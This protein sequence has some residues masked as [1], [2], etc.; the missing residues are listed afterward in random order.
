VSEG[1]EKVRNIYEYIIDDCEN[2]VSIQDYSLIEFI[3]KTYDDVKN[4]ILEDADF[5]YEKAATKLMNVSSD[6]LERFIKDTIYANLYC[7]LELMLQHLD[8]ENHYLK[9]KY[10][11]GGTGLDSKESDRFRKRVLQERLKTYDVIADISKRS[12]DYFG[13]REDK[14]VY[15]IPITMQIYKD[16]FFLKRKDENTEGFS[17]HYKNLAKVLLCDTEAENKDST[18]KQAR[19]IMKNGSLWKLEGKHVDLIIE[20]FE[21]VCLKAGDDF[22]FSEQMLV[23]KMFGLLTLSQICAKKT[24]FSEECISKIIDT[25][26]PIHR[27]GYC[28]LHISIINNLQEGNS[29]E[30]G[31]VI[32]EYIYQICQYVLIKTLSGIFNYFEGIGNDSRI[33]L[34]NKYL[35]DCKEKCQCFRLKEENLVKRTIDKNKLVSY[36]KALFGLP[37]NFKNAEEM[38]KYISVNSDFEWDL[39]YDDSCVKNYSEYYEVSFFYFNFASLTYDPP[40]YTPSENTSEEDEIRWSDIRRNKMYEEWE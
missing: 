37:D 36:I 39:H 6:L 13:V 22:S 35:E 19:K 8:P 30:F 4:A 24:G 10:F 3:N 17:I 16:A 21:N 31:V 33:R 14:M 38:Y 27:F 40:K 23:E 32:S 1:Y 28:M 7:D 20:L 26:Q 18:I 29:K 2:E 25:I 9:K 5:D 11:L 34:T 15:C 12:Y